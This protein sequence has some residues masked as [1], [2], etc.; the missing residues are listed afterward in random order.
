M[1]AKVIIIFAVL[2]LHTVLGKKE[3]VMYGQYHC[4]NSVSLL[5]PYH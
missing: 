2:R 1:Y 5:V 3:A 4:T